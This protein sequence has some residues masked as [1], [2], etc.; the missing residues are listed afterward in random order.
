MLCLAGLASSGLDLGQA[1]FIRLYLSHMTHFAAA[2]AAYCRHLPAVSPS[3][4]A[5]V[6]LALPD[7]TP[8]L[9][10]VLL[11][12]STAGEACMP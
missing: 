9:V 10:E 3:A 2:N 5:C 6:Q 12:V 7:D 4:R 1:L 11:P 8:V